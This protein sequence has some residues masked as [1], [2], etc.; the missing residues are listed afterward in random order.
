[1]SLFHHLQTSFNGGEISPRLQSRVDISIYAKG[2]AEILNMIPTV[3]GALLKRS[4]TRYRA[5]ALATTSWLSAF[6][7]NATQAYVIEWSEGKLRFLT[8]NAILLSGGVPVEVAVP[9][10]AAE[11]PRVST[12][13]SKDTL[14]MAHGSH[15]HAALTRTAADAF[16]YAALDLKGGPFADDNIDEAV[17]V[18]VTAAVG[19]G[20]TITANSGIFAAGHVGARFRVEADDF[21]AIPVWETGIDGHAVNDIRR[22]GS[23]VYICDQ[24]STGG[25]TGQ[26]PPVHT[27]GSEWDGSNGGNDINA[28]GPFGVRWKYLHDRFGILKITGFTSSTQVVATVERRL[29]DSVTSVPTYRWAQGLFSAVNGWPEHVCLWGGR[30]WFFQGFELA[31]SVSGSY[32]DHSEYNEDGEPTPDMAIRKTLDIPDAP[33]W[34]V[35]DR[36]GMV[37]GTTLGEYVINKIN[38]SE[39]LSADNIQVLPQGRRGSAPVWPL[40]T[41]E[42][43]MFLQRG[44]RKIRAA[45]YNFSDDRYLAP[46][47][48]IYARHITGSGIKQMTYQAEPEELLWALRNDGKLAAHPYNPEED[49]KGWSQGLVMEGA[50][51]VSAVSIPSPDGS[52]DDLQLLVNRGGSLSHEQLADWWDENLGLTSSDGFF[53]DSGLEYAGAPA[54]VFTGL[55]HL[56]NEEVMVLADGAE[57]PLQT[58]SAGGAVTLEKAASKVVIGKAYTARFVSLRPEIAQRDGTAQ[59]RITRLVNALA[60]VLDS[61][62]IR[63]GTAGGILDRL[64]KRDAADPMGGAPTMYSGWTSNI[65][66]TGSSDR[67]GQVTFESRA[68]FPWMLRAAKT[69]VQLGDR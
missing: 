14:Y 7:F 2:A 46:N 50:S 62:G 12:Q 13:Q 43:I 23:K 5:A 63:A 69:T 6:V 32:R 26:D 64:I 9:Y 49:V 51:V 28:V 31:G 60:S 53:V 4:G 52:L 29:P 36:Q 11:A 35:A 22:F 21:A 10:S 38:P 27:R 56:A 34:V 66:V 19:A 44:A 42:Q 18:T 67:A 55:E 41:A 45:A 61:F 54:T 39:I 25:R 47:N 30:L 3:E 59:T 65:P 48:T 68:P 37:I 8:N 17:T 33:L 20:V 40:P 57:L 58:V 15:P 24:I 1:M 16:S